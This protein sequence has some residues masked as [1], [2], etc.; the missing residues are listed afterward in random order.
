[1]ESKKPE[2]LKISLEELEKIVVELAKQGI[3]SEKIGLILRDQYGIPTA[4]VY[5]KK[6]SEIIEEKLNIKKQDDFQNI[7]KKIEK[8]KSHLAKNR[9][10][11]KVKKNLLSCEAKSIKLGKYYKKRVKNAEGN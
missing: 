2:W 1:M 5:G 7:N 10:D 11:R 3:P 4:R 8:I 9:Q 6:I